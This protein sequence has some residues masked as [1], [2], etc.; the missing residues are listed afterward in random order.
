MTN[1][2]LEDKLE[3]SE[4]PK[5]EHEVKRESKEKQLDPNTK[6]M[7]DDLWTKFNDEDEE[8]GSTADRLK[9]YAGKMTLE[10]RDIEDRGIDMN[11]N[12]SRF[13]LVS[14]LSVPL[15][16]TVTELQDNLNSLGE[17]AKRKSIF[18]VDPFDMFTH[19]LRGASSLDEIN[20]AWVGLQKRIILAGKNLRKY[21][22]EITSEEPFTSPTSTNP[23]LYAPLDST[24]GIEAR[25]NYVLGNI[26]HHRED[27]TDSVANALRDSKVDKVG[28]PAPSLLLRAFPERKPERNPKVVRYSSTGKKVE[29]DPDDWRDTST[30]DPKGKGR[31]YED[32][33]EKT[34]EVRNPFDKPHDPSHPQGPSYAKFS[35]LLGPSVSFKSSDEFFGD[36]DRFNAHEQ[37]PHF[38]E[39]VLWKDKS[40]SSSK[41]GYTPNNWGWYHNGRGKRKGKHGF[42]NEDELKDDNFRPKE[43]ESSSRHPTAHNSDPP[44]TRNREDPPRKAFKQSRER[45]RD[46]ERKDEDQGDNTNWN[47]NNSRQ[48][49]D[50]DP[51]DSSS[52]DDDDPGR[53]TS[54]KGYRENSSGQQGPPGSPNPEAPYGTIVPTIKPD[55]K[56]EDLP[57]WDGKPY[58][59]VQYFSDIQELA[60]MGGHLPRALGYWLWTRL[61][62]NSDVRRW[63]TLLDPESKAWAKSHYRNYLRMIKDNFLGKS[64]QLDIN[65]EFNSQTFRQTGHEYETP[66]GYIQRRVLYTRMLSSADDGGKDEVHIVLLRVPLSWHSVIQAS[67]I[68]R[69]I[70]LYAAISDNEKALVHASRMSSSNVVTSDNLVSMLRRVGVSVEQGKH[71][72]TISGNRSRNQPP[73]KTA[74]AMTQGG[75]NDDQSSSNEDSEPRS[76]TS[77]H[78]EAGSDALLR[79]VYQ[80]FTR[81]QRDPPADGY[82]FPKN[83]HVVTKLNRQPPSPCKVCGSANHWD[84]ECPD[85]DTYLAARKRS[86]KWVT[87]EEDI[88]PLETQYSSAYNALRDMR[89]SENLQGPEEGSSKTA[90]FETATP[91]VLHTRSELQGCKTAT[92]V[93]SDKVQ[94]DEQHKPITRLQDCPTSKTNHKTTV[95]EIED[96][97]WA[98]DGKMPTARVHLLETE[99]EHPDDSFDK[100]DYNHL[101]EVRPT[102]AMSSETRFT[103]PRHDF[104]RHPETYEDWIPS[105]DGPIMRLPKKRISPAGR[106]AMGISVLSMKGWVGNTYGKKIDLR[107]DSGADITLISDEFYKSLVSPPPLQ[108]GMRLKLWQ[109]T[110]KNTEILGFIRIPIFVEDENGRLLETEAEAYVVPGMTVPLLLGEDYQVAYEI[111]PVRNAHEGTKILFGQNGPSVLAEAVESTKDFHRLRQSAY[112]T[113]NFIRA[114]LHR[115]NQAKRTRQRRW[116]EPKENVIRASRDYKIRPHETRNISIEGNLGEN[117][118]WL[119]E[120]NLLASGGDEYFAI[121][122]V[123]ISTACPMVPVSNTSSHPKYV[124]RG[125]ILG[126]ISDPSRFFDVPKNLQSLEGQLNKA[127]MISTIIQAR[128][129]AETDQAHPTS[130]LSVSK[131]TPDIAVELE[132]D[133]YGPKTAAMPDPEVYASANMKQHLDW[134]TTFDATTVHVERVIGYWSRTFKGAEQRYATTEREALAAKEGLVKFQPFIEGE[135]VTLVTDHAALQ[136]ARTYENSNRRLAAWGAVFAAFNNLVIVHRAGRV[137]SNV[138]PLSRLP[139]RPPDHISPEPSNEPSIQA[140]DGWREVQEDV[141]NKEPAKQ[142]TFVAWDVRDCIEGMASGWAITRASTHRSNIPSIVENLPAEV[143]TNTDTD[144][145]GDE[146]EQPRGYKEMFEQPD[147]HPYL[148][149]KM[150]HETLQRV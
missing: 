134:S 122:N 133:Q 149:V 79:N 108:K 38:E 82:P 100:P 47:S 15:E 104:K 42:Y 86:A 121:P 92:R 56:T 114:K 130:H 97:Y 51:S 144:N 124:R 123:L 67:S 93:F 61:K 16:I 60:E 58:S 35:P 59:A 137:H 147:G 8:I 96:E 89:V 102:E 7:I 136:W 140:S 45:K 66:R 64:W 62:P 43:E 11:R 14:M 33:E 2:R 72:P 70:D 139:R 94:P 32:L 150:D 73:N 118:E 127:A 57:S 116:A 88:S 111:C 27:F 10:I 119:V 129:A 146:L 131:D 126:T 138:D 145:A 77:L 50:P 81:R 112:L 148:H 36:K 75:E 65:H 76:I 21:E 54:K 28:I 69:T 37:P 142:A 117:R 105:P 3:D 44:P 25:I 13:A 95:E 9:M 120:K 46:R 12:T 103:L 48:D 141:F 31:Q 49:P 4:K 143:P 84:K 90:G 20:A 113:A 83:D 52:S 24:R 74:Y 91:E 128:T 6:A 55:I 98:N 106:S 115:R 125:D 30:I 23:E 18:K 101:E 41:R 22:S 19:S 29:T 40:T 87:I 107:L 85:W 71:N 80:N 78:D 34:E 109:L 26:P 53:N 1:T 39:N 110:E 68:E 99:E 5:D 132:Q 17:L 63:F 135:T